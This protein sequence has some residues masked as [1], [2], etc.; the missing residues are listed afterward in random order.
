[1]NVSDSLIAD[2]KKSARW[3]F[4]Q[5]KHNVWKFGRGAPKL[6][7]DFVRP[8]DHLRVHIARI[9]AA[10]TNV[11]RRCSRESDIA[12]D[13]GVFKHRRVDLVETGGVDIKSVAVAVKVQ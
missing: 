10:A 9:V 1:M 13:G 7:H 3:Q 8:V 2:A 6:R 5:L 4:T 12:A 11:F